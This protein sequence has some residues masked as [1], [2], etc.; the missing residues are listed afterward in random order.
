MQL[1]TFCADMRIYFQLP[2]SADDIKA[3]RALS[4]LDRCV[5]L[6]NLTSVKE[7]LEMKGRFGA[8]NNC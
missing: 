6:R 8:V 7:H 3:L 1:S 5:G 2:G 4:L